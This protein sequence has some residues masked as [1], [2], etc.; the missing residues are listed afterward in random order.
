[1]KSD[2]WVQIMFETFILFYFGGIERISD[3]DLTRVQGTWDIIS[4][5]RVHF[6]R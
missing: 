4:G 6:A 1:M 5:M 3:S 2:F